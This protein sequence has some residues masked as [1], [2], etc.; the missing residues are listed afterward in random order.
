MAST[1]SPHLYFDAIY[2]RIGYD[3]AIFGANI[4]ENGKISVSAAPLFHR[5]WLFAPYDQYPD[6]FQILFLSGGPRE[7]L[8]TAPMPL[9]HF[10][11]ELLPSP[12]S[13]QPHFTFIDTAYTASFSAYTL[14]IND[15]FSAFF[16]YDKTYFLDYDTLPVITT[17]LH[18]ISKVAGINEIL[19]IQ[20][21]NFGST[22]GSGTVCFKA[23]DDGGNT[24]LKGLD[25]QYIKSWNSTKI[26]VSVPSYISKI[27][28]NDTT[29]HGGAGTGTIKIV[30]N[31]GNSCISAANLHI[32]Y[33]ITNAY[34]SIDNL[35]RRVYLTRKNCEYDFQFILQ[36]YF[37]TH[38]LSDTMINIIDKAFRDWSALT[39]LTIALERDGAGNPVI[40]NW[41]N[42]Q[43]K[44][45]IA[46]RNSGAMGTYNSVHRTTVG[47]ERYLYCTAGYPDFITSHISINLNPKA[48]VSPYDFSWNYD[49]LSSVIVPYGYASFYQ[50]FMHEIGHILL[51]DHV[52]NSSNLMYYSITSG[53]PIINLSPTDTTVLAVK[54]NIEASQVIDWSAVVPSLTQP[55]L[56]SLGGGKKPQIT[57]LSHNSPIICSKT[58]LLFLSSNYPTG[59]LWSTGETTQTIQVDQSGKY[60]VKFTD[61]DCEY[62]ADTV[63]I[64]FSL[65]NASFSVSNAICYNTSTGSVITNV[66]GL[67]PPYTYYWTG[68]GIT[69]ATTANLYN[70]SA[71]TYHLELSNSAGCTVNYSV[72]VSQPDP[73][74][75]TIDTIYSSSPRPT[76]IE[77]FANV[78]DG[79][80]P[81]T[82][83]WSAIPQGMALCPG[84]INTNF[85]SLPISYDTPSC[86][87]KLTVTDANGCQ[88]VT[89]PSG[90]YKSFISQEENSFV[91]NEI[92][93]F[94][95]P[96]SGTFTISNVSNATVYVYTALSSHV[97]T[98][99]H[100]SYSETMNIGH[101]PSGIYFIKIVEGNIIKNEK[102]ILS[103]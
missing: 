30:T 50:A 5:Y 47:S 80:L 57:I 27:Y 65:L 42:Y 4:S 7:K 59:N 6:G 22:Q 102:L 83:Q 34:D 46:P 52:N 66:R 72:S 77:F 71:G 82:Y 64:T 43:G 60:W 58:P 87:L 78:S 41:S 12:A 51:L 44:Y 11:I 75:V 76:P 40:E 36:N 33:S 29:K 101:L 25:N 39:G 97:K 92:T 15:P 10:Q 98:F 45:I 85:P 96:T 62:P 35:I 94:P 56:Y 48:N 21:L 99:E 73:L 24:Y 16:I 88:V 8:D 100:V 89:S 67:H 69:P 54:A 18:A 9:M 90:I 2:I 74:T 91:N 13:M 28:Q 1:N 55:P 95:N 38:P 84:F 70:L 86:R 61:D 68:N 49:T 26:E 79:T 31:N 53:K 14:N 23:A 3:P 37:G 19:T 93:L 63:N 32:P 81:Y 17:P 103:K 20:G